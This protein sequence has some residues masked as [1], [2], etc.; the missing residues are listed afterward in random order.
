LDALRDAKTAV[1]LGI[2]PIART[3]ST[4]LQAHSRELTREQTRAALRKYLC[5][6]ATIRRRFVL[7]LARWNANGCRHLHGYFCPPLIICTHN[8]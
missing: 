1:G 6:L 2:A 3:R 5:R 4:P 8:E 7:V